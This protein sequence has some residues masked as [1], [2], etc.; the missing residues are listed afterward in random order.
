MASRLWSRLLTYVFAFPYLPWVKYRQKPQ[1]IKRILVANHLLLG[2]TIMLTPLLKVLHLHY[3]K[4]SITFLVPEAFQSL[5]QKEPYGVKAIG[6]NPR[7]PIT[8]IKLLLKYRRYDIAYIPGD[9]RWSWLALALGAKWIIAFR[10]DKSWK[11]KPVNELV[12]W[13]HAITAWGDISSQLVGHSTAYFEDADWQSP[14]CQKF[15]IPN[16]P[17][18]VLHLGASKPHK[19]WAT[20]NWNQVADWVRSNGYQVV[21]SVGKGEETLLKEV[22]QKREDKCFHGN[23]NLAQLWTLLESADFIVCPDTG[24]AHLGRVV[25]TPTIAIFG[26][27]SPLV[28][29]A[30]DFWKNVKFFPLWE[31]EIECRNQTLLFERDLDW[32]KHCW[33]GESECKI[34]HCTNTVKASQVINIL[35]V[36]I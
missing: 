22:K 18:I 33:R 16:K 35:K 23:L 20:D 9:N 7:K 26:P 29:G 25:G 2:D 12:P 10:G 15:D 24:I 6:F 19:H 36:N 1:A 13:P 27:G 8:F 30:G 32:V 21:W 17:Y 4:A 5:Y 34:A 11:N 3:P 31:P 14:D 28:S